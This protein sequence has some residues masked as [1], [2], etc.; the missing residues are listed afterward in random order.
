MIFQ[1]SLRLFEEAEDIDSER[2]CSGHPEQ[3]LAAGPRLCAHPPVGEAPV[4]R[5]PADAAPQ[6]ESN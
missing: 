1:F 4:A 6:G 5:I 3:G 2:L